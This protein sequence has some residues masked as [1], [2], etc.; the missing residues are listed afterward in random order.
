MIDYRDLK[1]RSY[2]CA[3]E[4]QEIATITALLGGIVGLLIGV[5]SMMVIT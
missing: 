4:M 2:Y 1:Q 5:V 3:W